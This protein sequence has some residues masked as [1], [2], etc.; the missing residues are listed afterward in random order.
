VT[1]SQGI[2]GVGTRFEKAVLPLSSFYSLLL[3]GLHIH[4]R[5]REEAT[6]RPLS[7]AASWREFFFC[8][9]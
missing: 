8:A 2:L 1:Q 5:L 6:D 9:E 3:C 7:S 4:L